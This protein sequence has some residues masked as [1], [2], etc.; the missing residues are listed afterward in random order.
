MRDRP[1]G[2]Y[3]A[4]ELPAIY[5]EQAAAAV[6]FVSA[7]YAAGTGSGSSA[8]RAEPGSAG[9]AGVRAPGPGNRL[10]DNMWKSVFTGR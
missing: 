9:T 10:D 1:V 5:G 7:E 3:L 4:E 6:V 2:K 8:G